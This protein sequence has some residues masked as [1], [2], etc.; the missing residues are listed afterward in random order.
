M[1]PIELYTGSKNYWRL[2]TNVDFHMLEHVHED[3]V[4]VIC[5]HPVLHLEAP[6]IFLSISKYTQSL[7]PSKLEEMLTA[8][9][10]ELSRKRSRLPA[11]EL[12]HA[13]IRES[14]VQFILTR[15]QVV[16]DTA[17]Q[18]FTLLMVPLAGDTVDDNQ[19]LVQ[20][21]PQP[22]ALQSHIVQRGGRLRRY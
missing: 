16:L 1:P 13:V 15:A 3:V 7:E 18:S 6:R 21:V 12:M 9:R 2:R 14:I 22:A 5:F 10:E 11:N 20:V 19:Q 8:K 4:E 17:E